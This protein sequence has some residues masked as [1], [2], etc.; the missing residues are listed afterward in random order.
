MRNAH[1]YVSRLTVAQGD[2]RLQRFRQGLIAG[3]VPLNNLAYALVNYMNLYALGAFC[4]GE[5]K[6][7]LF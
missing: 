2:I 5:G 4:V 7:Q 6:K 1:K 3:L